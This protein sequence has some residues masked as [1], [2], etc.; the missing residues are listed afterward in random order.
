M[1][2]TMTAMGIALMAAGCAGTPDAG[3]PPGTPDLKAASAPL[4]QPHI[5]YSA[6]TLAN[7][8]R[9]FV[10]ED[11]HAPV[12]SYALT[13]DVGSRDE[14]EGRTGFAH[15]FEHM[16]FQG[17]ENVGK[18]EHFVLISQ[19]G[20]RMNGTTSFERTN[21]FATLPA[22]QLELAFF[23]EADRMRS[24]DL[25]QENLD[26][27]RHAVKEE[28]RLRVDNRPY[29]KVRDILFT[30]GYDTFG[31]NHPTIGSMEDLDAASLDDVRAFF[32]R[33]YVPNNAVL[34]VVGDVD[35]DE[36]VRLAE[37]YFG[38]IPPGTDLPERTSPK[39][40]LFK[41][42]RREVIHDPLAPLP[43]LDLIYPTVSGNLPDFYALDLF[44]RIMGDGSSSRLYQRLVKEDEL[45]T[46][47]GMYIWRLAGPS[48][49]GF[50]SILAP[51]KDVDEVLRIYDEE[52]ERAITEG[53]TQEELTRAR[54]A[55]RAELVESFESSMWLS[56]RW[57]QLI[58]NFNDP[59]LINREPEYYNAVTIEDLKRVGGYYLKPSNRGIVVSLPVEKGGEAD[60]GNQE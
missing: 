51:G 28:R 14:V 39:E 44:S 19:N 32:K 48:P 30:L 37:K 35:V 38:D 47:I 40:K 11:H 26:N 33:W 58:V 60:G 56:V 55:L 21:Y 1:K 41:G 2:R 16:M 57:G 42:E 22:N 8:L 53:F 27:Q 4:V 36:V 18:A 50:V 43:R 54:T 15:L 52:L 46:D 7:G 45:V 34:T 12:F 17:S 10:A 20:G 23:L 25:S 31:Y 5:D 6:H 24:L 9:I 29:G 59:D 49:V 3:P 13:Y